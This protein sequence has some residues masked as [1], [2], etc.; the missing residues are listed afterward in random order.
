MR[1]PDRIGGML[2]LLRQAWEEH[3]DWRLGQVIANTVGADVD[4]FN[5]EDD[6]MERL[7]RAMLQQCTMVPISLDPL[8]K[9]VAGGPRTAYMKG[10]S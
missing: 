1:A 10:G 5:I 3:P 2:D 8:M 7:L 6:V 4:L 9:Y